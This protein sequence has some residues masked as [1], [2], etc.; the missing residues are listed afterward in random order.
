[1]TNKYKGG[2]NMER[3]NYGATGRCSQCEYVNI[4]N[5]YCEKINKNVYVHV[6]HGNINFNCPFRNERKFVITRRN[7]R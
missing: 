3:D 1:M 5:F 2:T 7:E 4:K 6:L